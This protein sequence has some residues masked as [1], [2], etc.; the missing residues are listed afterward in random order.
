METR[1][2]TQTKPKEQ[3]YLWAIS[4]AGDT[5][6]PEMVF[7]KGIRDFWGWQDEETGNLFGFCSL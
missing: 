6:G 2:K 4:A 5:E 3:R 1:G 7:K